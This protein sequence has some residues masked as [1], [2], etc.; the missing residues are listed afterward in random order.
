MSKKLPRAITRT[1][2]DM[3]C[4]ASELAAAPGHH[5]PAGAARTGTDANT[6]LAI[7][8]ETPDVEVLPPPADSGLP[9]PADVSAEALHRSRAREIVERHTTYAAVGGLVPVPVADVAVVTAIIER[10][11]KALAGHYGVPFERGRVRA[12]V[13]GHMGGTAPAGFAAAAAI[14]AKATPNL[15]GLAIS[16][17]AAAMI[18]RS[19]GRL[20]IGHFE[21]GG[22]LLDLDATDI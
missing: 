2:D 1:I 8:R 3:R 13:I 16:S 7:V 14:L 19:I 6:M 4:S 15:F 20:F 21:S 11:A 9:P 22:T 5:M 12:I 17:V 18:T 10:M